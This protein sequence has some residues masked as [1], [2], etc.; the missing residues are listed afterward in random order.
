MNGLS[1][2]LGA[3]VTHKPQVLSNIGGKIEDD[4]RAI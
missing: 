2:N 4:G 3:K 1:M